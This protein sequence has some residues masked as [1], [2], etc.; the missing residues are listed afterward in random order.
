MSQLWECHKCGSDVPSIGNYFFQMLSNDNAREVVKNMGCLVIAG[1]NG[2]EEIINEKMRKG[3]SEE[4]ARKELFGEKKKKMGLCPK[5]FP[6]C[7]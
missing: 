1:Y 6:D 4:D 2:D 3:M 5:C 7:D